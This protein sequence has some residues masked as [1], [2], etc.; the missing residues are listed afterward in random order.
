[1]NTTTTP[2]ADTQ[3]VAVHC[4]DGERLVITTSTPM[5]KAH[6]DALRLRVLEQLRDQAT[7]VIVLHGLD[8]LRVS[9]VHIS[10]G[11]GSDGS[12][13]PTADAGDSTDQPS[14]DPP[15]AEAGGYD[16]TEGGKYSFAA[17]HGQPLGG[18]PDAPVRRMSDQAIVQTIV[19]YM[20][21]RRDAALAAWLA[22]PSGLD[23]AAFERAAAAC[24]VPDYAGVVLNHLTSRFPALAAAWAGK[25]AA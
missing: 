11:L 23:R 2:M 21:Q 5:T 17:W 19:G 25:D 12:A 3:T 1:M 7:P 24:E 22:G 20:D 16:Y 18:T 4:G 10:A 6:A 15:P 8:N 14:A 9:V 13:E